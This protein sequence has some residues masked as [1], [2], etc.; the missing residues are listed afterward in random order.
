MKKLYSNKKKGLLFWITGLSGSGKS[1]LGDSI[2]KYI[3][4]KYG[5]TIV[6]SGDDL[7]EIFSYKKFDKKSRFKYALSYSKICKKIVDQNINL[8]FST[9]SLFHEVRKWNRKN[10]P[11]Y[12]EIYIET[13]IDKLISKKKKFFYKKKLKNIVGKNIKAEFPKA[14]HIKIENRFNK[15]IN[16]TKYELLFKIKKIMRN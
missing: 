14:P 16:K 13:D 6:L 1:T 2:L 12:L 15:S 3:T 7:R 11:N 9:V 4:K 10:I 8:I 5:P